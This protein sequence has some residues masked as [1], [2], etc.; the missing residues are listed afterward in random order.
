MFYN[1]QTSVLF[2]YNEGIFSEYQS[3]LAL[4]LSRTP[5]QETGTSP[6]SCLYLDNHLYM[7]QVSLVLHTKVPLI[8]LNKVR[9]EVSFPTQSLHIYPRSVA[10]QC[11][12]RP[13][14]FFRIMRYTC[15]LL[16]EVIINLYLNGFC[17]L[18]FLINDLC[19][20]HAQYLE[21]D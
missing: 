3:L 16:N 1:C 4:Y 18:A 12:L 8:D 19:N 11:L 2:L 15:F 7:S 17:L 10:I 5:S 14:L 20:H 9:P 21:I 13:G 6:P